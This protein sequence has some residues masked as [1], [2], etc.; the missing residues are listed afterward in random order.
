MDARALRLRCRSGELSG[1][2]AGL[3]AGHVQANLVALPAAQ[4]FDF[5]LFCHRNPRP[6]PVLDVTA[7]GEVAPPRLAP[8]ADLRSDLPRYR[9]LVAGEE[10][11]VEDARE[12]W[13]ADL[14]A[15]LLGC[16]FSFEAALVRAGLPVRHIEEGRNVPMYRTARACVPAGPFAAPLVVS[17]RPMSPVQAERAVALTAGFPHAHGA[18]VAIGEPAALGIADL[19][20]PDFGDAVTVRPGEV[21]VFWACGVTTLLAVRNAAL[22]LAITHAP[23]HMFVADLREGG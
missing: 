5:W 9:I 2:T 15:F 6:C 16:S 14:C 1:P 11:E 17:M 7:P 23:G 21:P 18:P 10:R 19:A 13:R 12:A 22:S 8:D 20:A 3:A 4:A